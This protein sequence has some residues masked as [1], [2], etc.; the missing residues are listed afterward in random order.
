MV[1]LLFRGESTCNNRSCG[2]FQ[3]FGRFPFN[4]HHYIQPLVQY[5]QPGSLYLGH[6]TRISVPGRN[7]DVQRVSSLVLAQVPHVAR[8]KPGKSITGQGWNKK[9]HLPKKTGSMREFKCSHICAFTPTTSLPSSAAF[10]QV[11]MTDEDHA[12]ANGGDVLGAKCV[13]TRA[14]TSASHNPIRIGDGQ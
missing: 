7:I 12:D 4:V 13:G 9:Q 6:F 8:G 3:P 14:H 10:L 2:G 5:Y 1:H 11:K